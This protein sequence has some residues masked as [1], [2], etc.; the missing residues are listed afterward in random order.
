[1]LSNNR[2]KSIAICSSYTHIIFIATIRRKTTNI[3][4]T[5][6]NPSNNRA[7]NN[8]S[9]I[10]NIMKSIILADI[11]SNISRRTTTSRNNNRTTNDRLREGS[12]IA[13]LLIVTPV[14]LIKQVR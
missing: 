4:L 9:R 8:I 11:Q 10:L 5:A 1:M 14:K 2:L 12:G 6:R 3:N 7:N 13:V